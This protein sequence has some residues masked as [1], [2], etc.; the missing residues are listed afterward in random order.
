M[1]DNND[2]QDWVVDCDG[3]GQKRAV[4]DDRDSRVVIM[5]V[6]VEDGGKLHQQR[7]TRI[8]AED[9]GMQDWAADYNGKGQER[10]A[11]E[12]GDSRVAMMAVAAEDGGSRIGWRRWMTM[13]MAEDDSGGQ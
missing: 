5:A 8:V 6:V 1:V 12:G 2:T 11:R 9:N 7:R 4:R 3:E 10:A 13:A